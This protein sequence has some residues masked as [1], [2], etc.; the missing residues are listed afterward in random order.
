[1]TNTSLERSLRLLSIAEK[2]EVK[3]CGSEG[4]EISFKESKADY[5][6]TAVYNSVSEQ[7]SYYVN[8]VH[9]NSVDWAAIDMDGLK[10]L[11]EFCRLLEGC[12]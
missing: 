10:E 6:V 9:N 11:T 8:G 5:P 2:F 3:K 7:W 12:E 4:Y 1:M